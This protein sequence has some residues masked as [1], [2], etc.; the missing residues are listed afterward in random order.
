MFS[1]LLT[2]GHIFRS[3][4]GPCKGPTREARVLDNEALPPPGLGFALLSLQ[5]SIMIK[6]D[7]ELQMVIFTEILLSKHV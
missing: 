2:D 3:K 4:Q 1:S 6:M 7:R 5:V